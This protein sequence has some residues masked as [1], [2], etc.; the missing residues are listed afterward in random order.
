MIHC[1]CFYY[2]IRAG[3]LPWC[4]IFL[5][6]Y[7][8]DWHVFIYLILGLLTRNLNKLYLF[9][10]VQFLPR[11]GDTTQQLYVWHFGHHYLSTFIVGCNATPHCLD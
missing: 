2:L 5:P 4:F 8:N 9:T 10:A 11:L 3:L 7:R 1:N 6:A